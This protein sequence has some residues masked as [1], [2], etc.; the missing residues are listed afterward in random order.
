MSFNKKKEARE[1]IYSA[2]VSVLSSGLSIIDVLK[3]VRQELNGNLYLDNAISLLSK[4]K[5]RSAAYKNI[6]DLDIINILKSAEARQITASDIFKDYI[7]MK[8]I[9]EKAE[10]RMRSAL[11]EP[12]IMYLMVSFISYFAVNTF[13]NNFKDIPHMDISTIGFIRNYYFIIVAVPMLAVHFVII[14]FPEKVPLWSKVYRFVKSAGY[15]LVIKTLVDLGMSSVDAISFFRKLNDKQL[16]KRINVLKTHEKNIEGLTS[17]LSYYLSSVEIALMKTSV[18]FSEEKRTLSGIVEKRM[19]DV[20][21]TVS[22]IT[23]TFNKLLSVLSIL[24]IVMVVYVILTILGALTQ[25]V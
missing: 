13:Y 19:M 24:P 4:G 6:L 16:H 20:E 5:P 7:N 11:M 1:V 23:A 8:Y 15:L 21:K 2:E 9:I 18:K 22:G 14:K 12:T 10:S 3:N 25:R 17:A